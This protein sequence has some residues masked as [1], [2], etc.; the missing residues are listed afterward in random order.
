MNIYFTPSSKKHYKTHSRGK[1]VKSVGLLEPCV[2]L[3]NFQTSISSYENP[4]VKYGVPAVFNTDLILD[5]PFFPFINTMF[6]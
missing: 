5:K 1:N 2:N 6:G 4:S 3:L